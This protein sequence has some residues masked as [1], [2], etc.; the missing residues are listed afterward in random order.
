MRAPEFWAPGRGGALSAL[1]VP[2]SWLYGRAVCRRFAAT[3]AW[4]APVPV[5]CVGNLVAGGAGKTP[6]A[7]DLGA[8]LAARGI[9]VHFLLRG[10]GG[11]AKGPHRVD[12][13]NDTSTL[14]GDEALL[15]ARLAPTW[16][17][18]DRAAGAKAAVAAGAKA[19]VMDDGFQNPTLAKTVSLVVVDGAYGLGNG[20][21]LPAG[22]L[23]E[24]PEDGL[25]RAQAAIVLDPVNDM[26][27]ATLLRLAGRALPILTA[28]TVLGSEAAA[29]RG[30]KVFAFA[31]I[32]RPEKFFATLRAAG[33]LV[34]KTAAYSDHYPYAAD[35]ILALKDEA[36]RW[37]AI[38]VTTAKDMARI[39]PEAADGI[40]VLTIGIEWDDE[41][42][43]SAVIEPILSRC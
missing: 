10:Y 1:L 3:Q 41:A 21:V 29:F 4:T 12:P 14:V 20:R 26:I 8:R 31:G 13:A 5:L 40:H 23:R 25:A 6:I 36:A 28:R 34:R 35:E 16:V 19:I 43:L 7:L 33:A 11:T 39:P 22:P 17:A 24:A 37:Q 2:A 9:A 30:R 18:A 38:P 42:A 15:L 32:G 27:A